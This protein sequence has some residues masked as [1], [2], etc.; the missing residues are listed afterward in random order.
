MDYSDFQSQQQQQQQQQSQPQSQSQS[1]S[2]TSPQRAWSSQLLA[3]ASSTPFYYPPQS[4]RPTTAATTAAASPTTDSR[5]A[6]ASLSLN[7][8]SL[9]VA[10]PTAHSPIGTHPHSQ[11]QQGTFQDQPMHPHHPHQHPI[12]QHPHHS[13]SHSHSSGSALSVSP[14]TPASPQNFSPVHLS[15]QPFSF[16]FDESNGNGGLSPAPDALLAQR[17]PSTGSHSTSSSELAVEKSVPRKRSL[18]G[19]PPV[20]HGGHAMHA[21]SHS[22]STT[23]GAQAYAHGHG[24]SHGHSL[25]HPIITTT[26]SSPPPVSPNSPGSSS[27]TSHQFSL[28]HSHSH[29]SLSQQ[30]I[31]QPSSNPS[32]QPPQGQLDVNA[33][34][35]SPY[36]D[37]DGTGSYGM[38]SDDVS[39][40]EYG[41]AS[42]TN[43]SGGTGSGKPGASQAAAQGVM[44]KPITTNNFVTKLYQMINDPKSQHFISWTEHGT[45]FVVSNVGEFS[46]SILGSHFKHNNFSSFV[47]QLNMYG[48]HKINRALEPDPRER[49]RVELPGEVTRFLNEIREENRALWRE[50]CRLGGRVPPNI[51]A[52]L[53]SSAQSQPGSLSVS[54]PGQIGHTL[55]HSRSSSNLGDD[56]ERDNDWDDDEP[57]SGGTS[58]GAGATGADIFGNF[59]NVQAAVAGQSSMTLAAPSPHA[60]SPSPHPPSPSEEWRRWA[61]IEL[62]RERK[63][64]DK[65]VEV[66][67]TL[68]GVVNTGAGMSAGVAPGAGI[69]LGINAGTEQ[70]AEG[71]EAVATILRDLH[72]LSLEKSSHPPS[73]SGSPNPNP[74]Q[75]HGFS[76]NIYITSPT[77]P[78]PFPHLVGPTPHH[79][80]TRAGLPTLTIPTNP[81]YPLHTPSSSPTAADLPGPCFGQQRAFGSRAHGHSAHPSIT[82]TPDDG[83]RGDCKRARVDSTTAGMAVVSAEGADMDMVA[84]AE[85]DCKLPTPLSA[86]GVQCSRPRSDSASVWAPCGDAS[87][88]GNAAA[89]AA[90]GVA[91]WG[92]GRSGSGY[93]R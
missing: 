10:S 4:A 18:T 80:V 2:Q 70:A 11:G 34:P 60:H 71:D 37:I 42:F 83:G 88:N 67:R 61:E 75:S 13:H 30:S 8:N 55:T 41:N 43:G 36:D 87:V 20:A 40:D 35:S 44:G 92:R 78:S 39:D 7:M 52:T 26:A 38:M 15:P 22:F 62:M 63:R 1:Q 5:P 46:R 29:P 65:L 33:N 45:S 58:A 72:A 28:S 17:R 12:P 82:L 50:V 73:P 81:S 90:V 74:S 85:E 53:G 23:T 9:S 19:A 91:A 47:R 3:A 54:I 14:I 6:T 48:F 57:G 16:N 31:S 89:G 25:P 32:F 84:D 24:H 77:S 86:T 76:P 79:H 69:G 93:G 21:H 64:V 68:V 66:V 56:G 59:L 27:H 49:S 51:A